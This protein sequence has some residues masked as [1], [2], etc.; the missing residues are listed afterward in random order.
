VADRNFVIANAQVE[1]KPIIFCNDGF[2][3]LSGYARADVMQKPCTCDFLYGPLTSSYSIRHIKN[4]LDGCEEQQVEAQYYRKDGKILSS[5]LR[6]SHASVALPCMPGKAFYRLALRPVLDPMHIP[7][8]T[9]RLRNPQMR[10][11]C[12]F[13]PFLTLIRIT[14]WIMTRITLS[15]CRRLFCRSSYYASAPIGQRH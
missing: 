13:T 10:Y 15:L 14:I 2:C 4:A 12:V 1:N 7:E 9:V 3:E 8:L 6:A 11:S 5:F